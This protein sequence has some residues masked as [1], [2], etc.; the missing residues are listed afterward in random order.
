MQKTLLSISEELLQVEERLDALN[1]DVTENQDLLD[2][3]LGAV[4][5]R[6]EK[7]DNYAA[8]IR[9]VEAR[10]ATRKD[11]ARRM[12]E[13]ARL[14]QQKADFLKA[15]LKHFFITHD[16]KTVHTRRFRISHAGHGG[17][18]PVLLDLDPAD[19]PEGF[20][21]EDVR[22]KADT[23]AIREALDAG[24]ELEFARYGERGSSIRIK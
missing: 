15:R 13:L 14:D 2:A 24:R 9:D 18:L 17:K 20:R 19:L 4:G 3:Y 12:M 10:I 6:D 23:D 8:L 7:L 1:G 11:E 5:D 16:L 21:I 22:Y